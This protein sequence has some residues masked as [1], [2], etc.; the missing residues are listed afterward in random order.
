MQDFINALTTEPIV[1]VIVSGFLDAKQPLIFHPMYERLYFIFNSMKFE[2]CIDE[3]GTINAN[4]LTEIKTWFDLD[5]DDSF[6]LMSCY[7]QL[8]KTEQEILITSVTH[9]SAPFDC[10]TLSYRDGFIDRQLSLDPCNFFG[11]T[12]L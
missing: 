12:F 7:S 11:F 9:Q 10:L 1:D 4:S 3:F 2:L 5:E 8:F 6:S